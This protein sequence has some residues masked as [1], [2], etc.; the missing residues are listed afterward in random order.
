MVQAGCSN[1][2]LLAHQPHDRHA[3]HS[4][5]RGFLPAVASGAS[6]TLLDARA[7][8]ISPRHVLVDLLQAF[9]RTVR[10]ASA[11]G[12]TVEVPRAHTASPGIR[13]LA[14]LPLRADL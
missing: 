4:V 13:C 8:S 11:S 6:G 5:G 14:S 10:R 7:A 1:D 9:A 2:L 12:Q 3:D